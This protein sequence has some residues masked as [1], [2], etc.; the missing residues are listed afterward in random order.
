MHIQYNYFPLLHLT[1]SLPLVFSLLGL[2]YLA[3]SESAMHWL[4]T[5]QLQTTDSI[6]SHWHPNKP[7]PYNLFPPPCLNI[8]KACDDKKLSVNLDVTVIFL[9][10]ARLGCIKTSDITDHF[11]CHTCPLEFTINVSW[12]IILFYPA[13][14]YCLS[15]STNSF[16]KRPWCTL[17]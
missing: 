11:E 16:C 10:N 4:H 1:L 3:T 12:S 17:G 6:I 14:T 9:W 8:T 7:P 5:S 15:R 13:I 2:S